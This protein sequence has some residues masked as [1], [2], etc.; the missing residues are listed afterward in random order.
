MPRYGRVFAL[1]A[2]I[3]CIAICDPFVDRAAELIKR[4]AEL[5]QK[6][7]DVSHCQISIRANVALFGDRYGALLVC[8]FV[9]CV[10]VCL[11]ENYVMYWNIMYCL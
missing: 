6:L 11:Y 7:E 3:A 9:V 5:L 10:C 4:E 8:F 2:L 1:S